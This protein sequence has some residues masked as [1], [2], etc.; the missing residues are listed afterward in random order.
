M[1]MFSGNNIR[2]CFTKKLDN[3]NTHTYTFIWNSITKL[4]TF[5]SFLTH[6]PC[7]KGK[8]ITYEAYAACNIDRTGKYGTN[9]V[10]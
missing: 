6:K 4:K 7:W 3:N 8:T 9:S 2:E 10:S 1:K 5:L